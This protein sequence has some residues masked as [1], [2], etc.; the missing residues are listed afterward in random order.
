MT[1]VTEEVIT[2]IFNVISAATEIILA[3]DNPTSAPRKVISVTTEVILITR[4]AITATYILISAD[5]K[6]ILT[7][8]EVITATLKVSSVATEVLLA[9]NKLLSAPKNCFRSLQKWVTDFC[10]TKAGYGRVC[11]SCKIYFQR[12][13][14]IN[15]YDNNDN[16]IKFK[17][18]CLWQKLLSQDNHLYNYLVRW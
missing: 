11:L 16:E 8:E 5:T 3:T 13:Y 15:T 1:L 14:L 12:A 10:L 18:M 4:E 17:I 7:S 2:A 9:T 6:L